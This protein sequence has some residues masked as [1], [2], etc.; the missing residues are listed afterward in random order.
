MQK[1]FRRFSSKPDPYIYYDKGRS[2]G[3]SFINLKHA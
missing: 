2:T 3:P 1:I